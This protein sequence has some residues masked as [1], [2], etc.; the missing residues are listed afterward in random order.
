MSAIF[1]RFPTSYGKNTHPH[2]WCHCIVQHYCTFRNLINILCVSNV[3]VCV[4]V[5]IS[6]DERLLFNKRKFDLKKKKKTKRNCTASSE[7]ISKLK[8]YFL[9]LPRLIKAIWMVMSSPIPT[10][11]TRESHYKNLYI[12]LNII[13]NGTKMRNLAE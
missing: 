4:C 6:N 7:S 13:E 9:S 8:V 3:F 5:C 2:S 1:W 11:S 12:L 10:L